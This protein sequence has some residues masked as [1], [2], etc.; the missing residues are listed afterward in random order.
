MLT[1]PPLPVIAFG[2]GVAGEI[3]LALKQRGTHR[4]PG[5]HPRGTQ[6]GLLGPDS[7]C[8]VDRRGSQQNLLAAVSLHAE[9]HLQAGSHPCMTLNIIG[10]QVLQLTGQGNQT[11][12]STAIEQMP[13]QRRGHPSRNRAFARTAGAVYS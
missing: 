5:G 13:T 9:G 3:A 8:Y 7:R 10:G 11:V 6:T 2:V 4:R 1:V 12:Q